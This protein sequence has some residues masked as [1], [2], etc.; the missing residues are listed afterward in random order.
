VRLCQ[1][2]SK[3]RI[4]EAQA[5]PTRQKMQVISPNTLSRTHGEVQMTTND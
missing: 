3:T 5:I 4:C 2:N 1:C